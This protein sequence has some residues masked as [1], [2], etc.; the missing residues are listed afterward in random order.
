VVRKDVE[1]AFGVLQ[2]RFAMVRGPARFWDKNTLWYI[3]TSAII[4]HNMIIENER[5]EEVDYGYDQD[6]G[7]V[8]RPQEYQRRDPVL[9]EEFLKMHLDIEDKQAHERLQNDLV[10]HLR[11]L[12]GTS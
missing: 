6:G 11:A 1:R 10:E 5:N 4:M 12:H 9:L 3:M 7:E 8:L 2:A